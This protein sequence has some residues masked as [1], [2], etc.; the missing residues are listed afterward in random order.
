MH[1]QVFW[2][3]LAPF[4]ALIIFFAAFW[5][6]EMCD[7]LVYAS[8]FEAPMTSSGSRHPHWQRVVFYCDVLIRWGGERVASVIWRMQIMQCKHITKS[9]AY[10][11]MT[12]DQAD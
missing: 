2:H 4:W 10:A 6:W 12:C 11:C 5:V 8:H 9:S 1:P 3:E 7:R